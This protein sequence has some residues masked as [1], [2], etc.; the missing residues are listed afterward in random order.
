VGDIEPCP[1]IQFAKETIH[2][3]VPLKDKFQNSAFLRDFRQTA[4]ENTRG[5]IVLERRTC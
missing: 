1:I 4:A 5:C 3:D 2:D